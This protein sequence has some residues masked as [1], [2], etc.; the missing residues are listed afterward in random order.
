MQKKPSRNSTDCLNKD[1]GERLDLI[2]E[3]MDRVLGGIVVRLSSIEARMGPPGLG[4][5]TAAM[6]EDLQQTMDEKLQTGLKDMRYEPSSTL[7]CRI[8]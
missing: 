5:E 1:L 3:K 7:T 8:V 6:K 2:E 4:Y